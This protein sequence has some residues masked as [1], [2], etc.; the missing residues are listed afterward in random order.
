MTYCCGCDF[1]GGDSKALPL[2]P[3]MDQLKIHS[4]FVFPAKQR[5]G[6]PSVATSV[7]L[8]QGPRH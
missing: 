5:L 3:T 8:Q 1:V 2:R 4:F 6:D 7:T